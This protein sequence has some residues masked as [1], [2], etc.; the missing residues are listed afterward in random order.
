MCTTTRISIYHLFGAIYRV[1]QGAAPSDCCDGKG[2]GGGEG[3]HLPALHPFLFH[4]RNS[5][6]LRARGVRGG[7]VKGSFS[8]PPPPPPL[9][10][11]LRHHHPSLPPSR[12][13]TLFFTCPLSKGEI[14]DSAGGIEGGRHIACNLFRTVA[15]SAVK[16]RIEVGVSV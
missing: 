5:N 7:G 9:L 10:P 3:G 15:T 14:S 4:P 16:R 8:P 2:G 6:S 11:V 13:S 1:V 12:I